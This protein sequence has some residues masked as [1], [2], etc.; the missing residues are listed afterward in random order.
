MWLNVKDDLLST[1]FEH[2]YNNKNKTNF[3]DGA[4]VTLVSVVNIKTRFQESVLNYS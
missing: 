2:T 4:A 1:E 3:C